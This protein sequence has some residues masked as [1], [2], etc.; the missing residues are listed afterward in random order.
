MR[1]TYR[2]RRL[3]SPFAAS[4]LLALCLW[5]AVMALDG[6]AAG[7]KHSAAVRHYAL[8]YPSPAFGDLE[9]A[10]ESIRVEPLAIARAFSATAMVYRSKPFVY[11]DDAYNRWKVKPSAM[12]SDLLLRD[13]KSSGLFAGVFAGGDTENG[14]YTLGGVIEE[15]YEQ[16]ERDGGKA[17]LTLDVTLVGRSRPGSG[18]RPAFQKSYRSVKV[19]EAN[20]AES[21]ARA[22]SEAMETLSSQIILDVYQAVRTNGQTGMKAPSPRGLSAR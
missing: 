21:M 8:E 2:T 14:D 18:G 6:C 5:A 12:I 17:V 1:E 11:G 15:L 16:E 4:L 13:M 7:G 3:Q 9:R 20:D 10:S 19:M 22:M